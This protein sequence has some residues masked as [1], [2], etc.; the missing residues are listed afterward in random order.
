[1]PLRENEEQRPIAPPRKKGGWARTVNNRK[2]R[3]RPDQAPASW[4][5]GSERGT[6]ENVIVQ[7]PDRCLTRADIVKDVVWLPAAIKVG[8]SYQGPACGKSGSER[9]TNENVIVQIPD[10]RLTTGGVKK[11]I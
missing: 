9:G 5:S 6:N 8:R 2:L 11:S 4:K 3:S 7:I 1:M 10:R